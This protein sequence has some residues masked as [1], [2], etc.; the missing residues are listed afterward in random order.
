MAHKGVL[1]SSPDVQNMSPAQW[2][3]EYHAL[4]EKEK[5]EY[6]RN[7]KTFKRVMVSLLGLN[8]LRP[9]DEYGVPKSE[10]KMTEEERDQYI[11]LVAWMGRMEMLG[12]VKDQVEKEA[13][14]ES[15]NSNTEYEKM[16][17]AIDELDGDM[18]PIISVVPVPDYK[19]AKYEKQLADIK[20]YPSGP[21]QEVSEGKI[22]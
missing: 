6:E 1:L 18:E 2:V 10:E 9:E 3:F 15:S 11:P 7:F 5:T 4:Q 8:A 14:I 21:D 16:V 12:L 20:K 22:K 13:C 19:K 17:A